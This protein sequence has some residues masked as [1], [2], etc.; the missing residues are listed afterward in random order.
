MTT[1]ADR[2]LGRIRIAIL[3]IKIFENE[4][5]NIGLALRHGL[6]SS[7]SAGRWLDEIGASPWMPPEI[8]PEIEVLPDRKR[9]A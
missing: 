9:R 7:A 5:E 2:L 8:E 4:I 6:V 1:E 3:E